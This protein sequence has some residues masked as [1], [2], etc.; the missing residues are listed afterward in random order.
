[1]ALI[2]IKATDELM[3]K[4]EALPYLNLSESVRDAIE[5][6]ITVEKARHATK[7]RNRMIK[8]AEKQDEITVK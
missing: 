5:A 4:M 1:M 6:M 2:T 7:D 3:R 8:A